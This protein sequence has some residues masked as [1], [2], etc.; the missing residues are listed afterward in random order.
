MEGESAHDSLRKKVKLAENPECRKGRRESKTLTT[1]LFQFLAREMLNI[2]GG[3]NAN[4][5]LGELELR[6]KG[7]MLR[8]EGSKNI[9]GEVLLVR[10]KRERE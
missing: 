6:G 8:I 10:G 1:P 7:K 3:G 9:F 2:E 4:G 5:F